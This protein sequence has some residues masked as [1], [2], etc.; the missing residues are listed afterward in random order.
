MNGTQIVITAL[1]SAVT[2]IGVIAIIAVLMTTRRKARATG[3]AADIQKLEKGENWWLVGTVVILVVLFVATFAGI[4]WLNR[5]QATQTVQVRA[6]QF[7]FVMQPAKIPTGTVDFKVRS[8]DVSHGFGLY[9][10]DDHLVTQIQVLPKVTS[11]ATVKLT[12]TGVYRIRC[13]EFCGFNHHNM[14]GQIEVTQ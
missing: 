8:D 14:V 3:S 10:P 6:L 5:A 12:K 1:Y 11:T 2:L 7:A 4:P 9:D 13:L